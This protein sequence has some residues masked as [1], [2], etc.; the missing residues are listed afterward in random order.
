MCQAY[1]AERA[2]CVRMEE[3]AGWCGRCDNPRLN[4]S[5]T[6]HLCVCD[7][8]P[9]AQENRWRLK[10]MEP[11]PDGEKGEPTCQDGPDQQAGGNL[12]EQEE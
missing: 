7:D 11:A 8:N 12:G 2:F 5:T 4:Y 6:R 1:E 9:H 3:H 10:M